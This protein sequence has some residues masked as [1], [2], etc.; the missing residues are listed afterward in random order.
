MD[1]DII[2]NEFA[3]PAEASQFSD[4]FDALMR[5]VAYR[6]ELDERGKL[7]WVGYNGSEE[8]VLDREPD[9][10]WWKRTSTR[11]LSWFVPESQL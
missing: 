1:I 2:L 11:F 5:Q 6:I 8:L 4:N 9:T 10:T 7:R 3:S